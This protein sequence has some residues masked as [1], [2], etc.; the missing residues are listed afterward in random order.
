MTFEES[1]NFFSLYKENTNN[2]EENQQENPFE[3][4]DFII[5]EKRLLDYHQ[6]ISLKQTEKIIDQLKDNICNIFLGGG[7]RGTG[8]FMKIKFP[9]NEHLLPVLVTCN[10]VINKSFLS[11]NDKVFIQIND[12]IKTIEFKNRIIYNNEKLDIAIIEIKEKDE[13]KNFLILD[14]ENQDFK[15]SGKTIYILQYLD[16]NEP[17]VAYGILKDLDY[18]SFTHCCNTMPGSSGS[19][20]LNLANNKVIGIHIGCSYNHN[21]NLGKFLNNPINDFIKKI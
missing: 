1:N 8:F 11:K 18:L 17:S 7:E 20:I 15:I 13:I 10:H 3:K 2:N 6:P 21:Y 12:K 19:P 14:E 5:N 16:T 4:N 9:D